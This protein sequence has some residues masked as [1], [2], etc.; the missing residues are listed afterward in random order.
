[1]SMF[2]DSRLIF[3]VRDGRD[4]VNSLFE[5]QLPGGW[6]TEHAVELA[7]ERRRTQ[8]LRTQG[9]LWVNRMNAVQSAAATHSASLALTIRYE[10]LVA[11]TGR[12]VREV[13]TWVGIERD[14]GWLDAAIAAG[15][16]HAPERHAGRWRETMTAAEQSVLLEVIGS[17]VAELG[18]E[19][20]T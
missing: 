10:D 15:S 14:Q 11:E 3:L 8:F 2:P 9:R 19:T 17:K 12:V 16:E 20:G 4:V 7:S 18:Y 5:S 13:L 6:R 1:M